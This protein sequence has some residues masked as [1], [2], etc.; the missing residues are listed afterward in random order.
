ML[1]TEDQSSCGLYMV[2]EMVENSDSS[3]FGCGSSLW[4]LR[5][6]K[7]QMVKLKMHPSVR[8]D[9]VQ[10]GINGDREGICHQYLY[11]LLDLQGNLTHLL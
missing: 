11:N 2:A 9:V 6:G 10:Y 5:I 8:T 4:L 7:V 3:M 1:E